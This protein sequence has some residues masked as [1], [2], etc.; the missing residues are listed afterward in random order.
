MDACDEKYPVSCIS[1]SSRKI[2]PLGSISIVAVGVVTA[3][4]V[5]GWMGS[6]LDDAAVAARSVYSGNPN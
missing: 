4:V 2:L 3:G 5:A 6:S 1:C